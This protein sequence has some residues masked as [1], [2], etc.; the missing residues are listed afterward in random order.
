MLLSFV[1]SEYGL[2]FCLVI[3]EPYTCIVHYFI[4]LS[5]IDIFLFLTV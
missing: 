1:S 2:G 4:D 5:P 3:T